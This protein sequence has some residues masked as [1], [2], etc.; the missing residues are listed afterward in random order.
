MKIKA[1]FFSILFLAMLAVPAAVSGI[2][3][4]STSN[5]SSEETS[6]QTS[7]F[8]AEADPTASAGVSQSETPA[9]S[10]VI[11]SSPAFKAPTE[12]EF[13]ILDESTGEIHRIE[14]VDFLT[15]VV[16]AE[17][18]VT[19]EPEALK[20]QAVVSMTF[21][22]KK[23]ETQQADPD[24]ELKGADFSL[25]FSKGTGYLTKEQ[26]Q[27][28][29]GDQYEV[30][31][32]KV[33]SAC[34]EVQNLVLRDAKGDLITAAY[35]AISSGVTEAGANIFAEDLDYLTEVPSPGDLLVPSYQT[36]VSLSAEDFQAMAS[37]LWP[38]IQ[39]EGEPQGWISEIQ[40]AS[41]G[42]VLTISIGSVKATGQEVS[43]A[44]SLRSANF[45]LVFTQG[46][47]LFTVRG[48]G[49]GVGMSQYGASHM[50]SQGA[51]YAE[52]LAW[53]Y[54]GTELHHL[55]LAS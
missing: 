8:L 6:P 49:H 53:Y 19:F 12:N 25:D 31:Y 33:E 3:L 38:E 45:D 26:L 55:P 54:P 32:Q 47:F 46:N 23:K 5:T 44:F 24:A 30:N 21:F 39:L 10:L 35:H 50:A 48:Y 11:S 41:T 2:F 34:R 13:R 42:L 27:K 36:S 22:W 18:P 4:G 15:G 16:A 1:I 43:Q 51:S 9:S 40:K 20:A 52:I 7:A 29:W 14:L 17:M 37:T 28:K